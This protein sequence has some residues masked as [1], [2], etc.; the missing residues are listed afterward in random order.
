M[1]KTPEFMPISKSVQASVSP[2]R[3]FVTVTMSVSWSVPFVLT[4]V[5]R[6][7]GERLSP[8][9]TKDWNVPDEVDSPKTTL[10]VPDVEES[11]AVCVS[12]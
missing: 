11:V 1:S 10:I 9:M 3:L 8:R 6:I 5:S 4:S 7:V 12:A 2:V